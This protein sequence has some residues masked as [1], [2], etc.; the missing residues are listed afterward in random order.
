MQAKRASLISKP[1][2]D[3]TMLREVLDSMAAPQPCASGA[4]ASSSPSLDPADDDE[5]S[6]RV[7][8]MRVESLTL[9][10]TNLSPLTFIVAVCCD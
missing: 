3:G 2:E 7:H 8:V 5:V 4:L 6:D 9:T 1:A 10:K